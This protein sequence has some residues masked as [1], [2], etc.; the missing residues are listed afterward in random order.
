VFFFHYSVFYLLY[1]SF[2][3]EN[4]DNRAYISWNVMKIM[5]R[6]FTLIKRIL[7]RIRIISRWS[8]TVGSDNSE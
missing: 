7:E 4:I 8:M 3:E 6:G 2:A 1:A 5:E